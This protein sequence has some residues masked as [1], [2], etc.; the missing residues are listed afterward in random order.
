VTVR[1]H[2]F[3]VAKREQILERAQQRVR[4]RRGYGAVEA[5]LEHGVGLF[6]SQLTAALG[7]PAV[8]QVARA[9]RA[10]DVKQI[11]DSAAL[12]GRDL[13][14]NGFGVAQVVLGYRDVSQVVTELAS[15]ANAAIEAEDFRLFNR[16]LDDAVAGAVT[17]Y[18]AERERD[19]A[20]QGT[21]R[22]GVLAHE[23]RNLLNTASL[24]FA[25]LREGVVAI[26]SR[27]GDMHARSLADLSAL[28]ERAVAEVRLDAGVPLLQ[29]ISL[30]EFISEIGVSAAMHAEGY[31]IAL[32]VDAVDDEL[33]IDVDRQLLGSAVTN[34]LQNAFKFT[35]PHGS[36]S[37]RAHALRETILIEVCDECGGLPAGQA[38]KLFRP[39]ERASANRSGLG[40]GLTIARTAVQANAGKLSV[41][42]VPG[43]GCVFTIELP[44]ASRLGGSVDSARAESALPA[45]AAN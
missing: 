20:Y 30:S 27:I 4:G 36:V 42:D 8:P 39:F 16:C 21:E 45:D 12:N 17:A 37:L 38:E 28:I 13:L 19:L 25:V 34:L 1:L 5:K 26:D 31:G 44:S 35:R 18:G 23:L 24:S 3:I 29:R 9:L 22:M 41:R 14:R 10:G 33:A 2:E 7:A 6:L 43:Q 15:E 40:L 32:T 11:T